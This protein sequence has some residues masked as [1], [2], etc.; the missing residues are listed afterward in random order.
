MIC[1]PILAGDTE[2]ALSK[3]H[4]AEALA[5]LFELRLDVMTSWQLEDIISL[6]P[7][8]VIITYRSRQ[9][10]GKGTNDYTTHAQVLSEA[11]EFGAEFVDVEHTMP[12]DLQQ[13]LF[14]GRGKSRVIISCHML[15]ETPTR[16]GL[17]KLFYR[18]A[19]T[20]ADIV[21]LVTYAN[22]LEDNLRVLDLISCARDHGTPIIALCMGPLG[23][24][25]RIVSPILG[26]FLTFAS[27]TGGEES[28]S[29]QLTAMEVRDIMKVL[30][31]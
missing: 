29:G 13:K 9:Q 5:D 27:F 18:L 3:M 28:A 20:G 7:K 6:T 12:S 31:P 17:E 15:H 16:D 10:G 14:Q 22:A 24:V 19:E 25:S 2:E 23:R 21:K 8:P 4:G 26:G 11:L 1:I 30:A